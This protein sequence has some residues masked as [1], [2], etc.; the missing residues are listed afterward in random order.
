V[1][2]DFH[3]FRLGRAGLTMSAP[4]LD[5]SETPEEYLIEAEL[6]GVD[7]KDVEVSVAGDLLTI[8]G[9]KKI[10]RED[11][12]KDFHLVERAHGVFERTIALPF[13]VDP[14]KIT[15]KFQAGVLRISATKPTEAKL[16]KQK[17][18]IAPA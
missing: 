12:S 4:R 14:R 11:K 7:I 13:A 5:V 18:A 10:Y 15:A 3:P 9:E 2:D 8:K 1:F 6:P 16:E 17:I